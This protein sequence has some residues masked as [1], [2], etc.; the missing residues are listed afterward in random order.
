M[1]PYFPLE[2]LNGSDLIPM[3]HHVGVY[4]YRPKVL[5][6][7]IVWPE[8]FLESLEGLEQIRFLENN[9]IVKCVEVDSKGRLF[10]EL[11]N[12]QDI[13]RIE[14]VLKKFL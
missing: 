13:E 6:D 8:G 4:A 9:R 1:I 7:Y 12:P 2:K 11:N 10:W 3:F 14:K 5:E